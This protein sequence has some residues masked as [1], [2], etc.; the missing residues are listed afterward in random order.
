MQD[1][2]FKNGV[3]RKP[4]WEAELGSRHA[5]GSSA[6]ATRFAGAMQADKFGRGNELIDFAEH[7]NFGESPGTFEFIEPGTKNL[8]VQGGP[9]SSKSYWHAFDEL[10]VNTWN[11]STLP[12][13]WYGGENPQQWIGDFVDDQYAF[14]GSWLK[15]LANLNQGG[16]GFLSFVSKQDICNR[17]TTLLHWIVKNCITDFLDIEFPF[18]VPADVEM[19]TFG[20]TTCRST[21]FKASLALFTP[22]GTELQIPMAWFASQDAD[23]VAHPW[24]EHSFKRFWL[25][26]QRTAPGIPHG[27]ID[28]FCL[29][30]LALIYNIMRPDLHLNASENLA[31]EYKAGAQGGEDPLPQLIKVKYPLSGS[32]AK[33][34]GLIRATDWKQGGN[35]W[36]SCGVGYSTG[37]VPLHT[38]TASYLTWTGKGLIHFFVDDDGSLKLVGPYQWATS[39]NFGLFMAAAFRNGMQYHTGP[40]AAGYCGQF[41]EYATDA[42]YL[43]PA[44]PVLVNPPKS[45]EQGLLF[46]YGL[47]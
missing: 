1:W 19:R 29:E 16:M 44:V 43:P 21:E 18:A 3:W 47:M 5:S 34:W 20:P 37:G 14:S 23:C 11:S 28:V 17:A 32:E 39:N 22:S 26:V 38:R 15:N 46:T 25:K 13:P 12:G 35:A 4:W 27:V 30:Y 7:G 42:C 45:W 10:L 41:A 40:D 6:A 8:G 31:P 2:R 9:M 33:I 24:W 36:S